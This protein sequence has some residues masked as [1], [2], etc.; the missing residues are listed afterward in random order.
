MENDILPSFSGGSSAVEEGSSLAS[1][2]VER[3][4]EGRR[5]AYAQEVSRLV[6]ASF[7]LIR[8]RGVLEPRV[9]EIVSAAGLS[10][11]AF[12]RHFRSKDELLVAVLDAGIRRLADYLAHR[13]DAAEAPEAKIEAWLRGMA[14]QALDAEAARATRP[15]ALSRA[16]LSERFPEEVAESER[17][18]TALLHEPIAAG[19]ATGALPGADPERDAALL[20]DLAM[21]W[22]QRELARPDPSAPADAE[23]WVAFALHGLRRGRS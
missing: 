2:S 3:A 8:E 18:L 17:R 6:E 10:N 12:Y 5:A 7:G 16:R 11:Q 19:G 1:R 14:A 20:Y 23:H 15:F 4:L 9:G 21:G 13:M 22:L